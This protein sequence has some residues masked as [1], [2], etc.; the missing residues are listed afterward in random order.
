[1]TPT[2]IR[3]IYGIL[4]QNNA[5]IVHFSGAPKGSGKCRLDHMYPK[6]LLHVVNEYAQGGLSCS[7]IMPTDNFYGIDRNATGCI[8]VV[9]GL[10]SDCSVTSATPN[11]AG[12]IENSN[13]T[14]EA[15]D[16]IVDTAAIKESIS[17]RKQNGYNEWVVRDY[18]SLGILAAPPYEVMELRIPVFPPNMPEHLID[19][20]PLPVIAQLTLAQVKLCFPNNRIFTLRDGSF[21]EY[22]NGTLEPLQHGD[23]YHQ[24]PVEF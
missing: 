18:V 10:K 7:T 6:D 24:T 3:A 13:G 20:T 12:S 5:L 16:Q 14:R 21:F 17:N 9:L 22:K 1:M 11:D 2:T 8:G 23:I 4:E 15:Q 19:S